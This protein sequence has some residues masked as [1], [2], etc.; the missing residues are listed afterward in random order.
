M[1]T[2]ICITLSRNTK[3]NKHKQTY[4]H[5]YTHTYTYHNN[6]NTTTMNRS[7]LKVPPAIQIIKDEARKLPSGSG[8]N[9]PDSPKPFVIG[10]A[11]KFLWQQDVN[12]DIE[13]FKLAPKFGEYYCVFAVRMLIK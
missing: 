4:T 2:A 6:S 1:V 5:I 9:S 7:N 13:V 3:Q 10:K 8:Q 12:L 11:H